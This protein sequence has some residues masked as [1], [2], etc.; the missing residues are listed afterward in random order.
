ML[1]SIVLALALLSSWW[2]IN[3]FIAAIFSEDTP[4]EEISS[5]ARVGVTLDL[6]AVISW[7]VFY[8]LTH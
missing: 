4:E 1:T 5:R 7:A 3:V 8:G 2:A 6:I